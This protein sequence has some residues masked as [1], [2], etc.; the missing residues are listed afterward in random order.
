[1]S[2]H[3]ERDPDPHRPRRCRLDW[4]RLT[5]VAFVAL[6]ATLVIVLLAAIV[7]VATR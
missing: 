4:E 7:V 5:L 6:Q 3:P 2:R 1:M